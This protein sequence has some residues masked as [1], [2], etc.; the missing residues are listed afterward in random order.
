MSRC[1]AGTRTRWRRTLTRCISI[2]DATAFQTARCA[3][4][5]T[6]KSASR[7]R[8][9]RTRR[10]RL[11]AAVTPSGSSYASSKS[12]SPRT[13][14]VPSSRQSPAARVA[15]TLRRKASAPGGSKLPMFDPRN[16][17]SV[18]PVA[19]PSAPIAE[20]PASYVAWCATT[21]S[22]RARRWFSRANAA[23]SSADDETSTRCTVSARSSPVASTS[24]ASFLPLPG[25]SSMSVASA[26][27]RARMSRAWRLSRC[28]SVRAI[29]YHGRW[30]I[31]SNKAEPRPSYRYLDGSWRGVSD[32]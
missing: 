31:A 8:L 6:S 19:C 16:S 21:V 22:S 14:S 30:Q 15:R 9:A 29:P 32:R 11:N 13:R 20:R 3:K 5:A 4:P 18:C 28:C 10:L 12:F 27:T 23:V 1:D 24:P 7:S 26:P 17:T 25:P 2:R